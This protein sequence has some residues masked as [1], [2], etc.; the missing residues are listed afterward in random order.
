MANICLVD[1]NILVRL[2]TRDMPE[3]YLKAK[4]LIDSIDEFYVEDTA[5][6]E[7]I[8]ALTSHY[9][10]KRSQ[11]KELVTWVLDNPKCNCNDGVFR[12]ALELYENHHSLSFEDCL[13]GCYASLRSA[14][15]LYTFD[16]KLANQHP[17]AKLL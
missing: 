4:K 6:V 10:M 2:L 12:T 16:K 1:T 11:V 3:A 13:L 7:L 8:F 14:T 15:P 5:L 9:G 17:N